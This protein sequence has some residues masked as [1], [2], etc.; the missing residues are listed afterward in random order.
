MK[1]TAFAVTLLGLSAS[2]GVQGFVAKQQAK[3]FG[4]SSSLKVSVPCF[5][6]FQVEGYIS[7]ETL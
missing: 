5:D 3:P 2:N 1:V 4:F 6:G 7:L